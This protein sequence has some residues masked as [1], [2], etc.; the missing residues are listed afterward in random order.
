MTDPASPLMFKIHLQPISGDLVRFWQIS[1]ASWSQQLKVI[2]L[3]AGVS[4]MFRIS[5]IESVLTRSCGRWSIQ[6]STFY[7]NKNV[8]LPLLC[9]QVLVYH[10]PY[11]VSRKGGHC[12]SHLSRQSDII[13]LC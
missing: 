6:P 4:I 5:V 12:I 11:C 8:T 2:W 13:L 1:K 10:L 7:F 9:K 3:L